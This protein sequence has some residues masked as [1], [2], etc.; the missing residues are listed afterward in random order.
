[1]SAKETPQEETVKGKKVSAT[2]YEPPSKDAIEFPC[3]LKSGTAFSYTDNQT[4]LRFSPV[5]PVKVDVAPEA[6][7]HLACQLDAGN[8]VKA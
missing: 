1:M 8:I 7:S 5:T 4:G 2:R 6:G 3:F